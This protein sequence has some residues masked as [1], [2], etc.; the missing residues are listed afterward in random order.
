MRIIHLID[1]SSHGGATDLVTRLARGGELEH[2]VLA[3]RG[4]PARAA[5]ESAGVTVDVAEPGP[6]DALRWLGL[7][8]L[9]ARTEGEVVE[10]HGFAPALVGAL[11]R[12]PLVLSLHERLHDLPWWARRGYRQLL[13]RA[14]AAI[15]T[16]AAVRRSFVFGGGPRASEIETVVPGIDPDLDLAMSGDL[17]AV[18]DVAV[19]TL[20]YGEL[21][22]EAVT[23][24]AAGRAIVTTFPSGLA[25][26]LGGA[27]RELTVPA[28]DP[29]ALAAAIAR[30]RGDEA[31]RR[32]LGEEA[33][34]RF[35]A[36]W[37]RAREVEARSAIYRRAASSAG[38]RRP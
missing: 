23:A 28:G 21:P 27:G 7:R 24:M 15:A 38:G 16:S 6:V 4:G 25:E 37:G 13:G 29:S 32:R 10:A 26:A 33:R 22:R 31:L 36:L 19:F 9:V 30:A 14:A 17:A 8:R 35:E 11:D 12:R 3:A 1:R 2:V 18:A 34:R 20:G 5:L